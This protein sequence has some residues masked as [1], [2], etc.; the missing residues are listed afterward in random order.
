[1]KIRWTSQSIRLRITPSELSSLES[2]KQICEQVCFPGGGIWRL[3]VVPNSTT[4]TVEGSGNNVCL[5]LAA[6]DLK[7]LLNHKNEGVYFNSP[8]PELLSYFI[9]KD[10]PCA[11]PKVTEAAEPVTEAFQ[12]PAAF[13]ARKAVTLL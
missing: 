5:H 7:K 6:D 4:T 9:E 13:E 10:F 12:P 3:L 8:Q 2:G 1:M 11:H